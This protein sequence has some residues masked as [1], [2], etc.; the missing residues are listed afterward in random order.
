MK[1]LVMILISVPFLASAKTDV[2]AKLD[3]LKQNKESSVANLK[4]Y[5]ENNR[6]VESNLN[7]VQRAIEAL[8]AQKKAL[9]KQTADVEKGKKDVQGNRK[10]IEGWMV[11]EKA[12]LEEEKKH[13]ADLKRALEIL[14]NNK[15]QRELAIQTYQDKLSKVEGDLANWSMKKDEVAELEKALS[16][17]EAQALADKKQLQTKRAGYETEIGKW[18]KQVRVSEREYEQFSKLK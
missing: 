4:Q 10:K 15:N 7:E 3:Q 2:K 6:I 12:K 8:K 11:S 13:I 9:W 14:E 18:R 17:K 5:E 1:S 16:E